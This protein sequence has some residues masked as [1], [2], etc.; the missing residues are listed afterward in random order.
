[1]HL[2]SI[3]AFRINSLIVMSLKKVWTSYL[4]S[5]KSKPK[6]TTYTEVIRARILWL[7]T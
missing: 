2:V 6:I 1:M 4:S 3:Y 7:A 5:S